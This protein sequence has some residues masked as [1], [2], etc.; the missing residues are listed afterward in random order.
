MLVLAMG[1]EAMVADY[2]SRIN[3][4]GTLIL[5]SA[6]VK[7]NPRT[8]DG[9]L[10][11]STPLLNIV[12]D[13][14]LMEKLLYIEFSLTGS[15]VRPLVQLNWLYSLRIDLG[16]SVPIGGGVVGDEPL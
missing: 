14:M 16:G 15:G 8:C 11:A 5:A 12:R 3:E 6:T 4:N 2:S 7:F 13:S 1:M 9:I 10:H